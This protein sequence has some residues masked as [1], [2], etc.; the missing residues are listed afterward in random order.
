MLA[1]I[2]RYKTHPSIVKIKQLIKPNHQFGFGKFDTKEVWDEINRLD[3]SKSVSGNI[4]TTILKKLSALCIGEVTKIANSMIK[5]CLFPESLKKAD[6]SPVFKTRE[7]TAK[8]NFRPISVFP[9]ISKVFERLMSKQ[10]T[11][12]INSILPKL[13][14]EFRE[15]YSSQDALFRVI[16]Q[17]RKILDRSGKVGMV[18]MDLSKAYD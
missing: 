4:P 5:S 18:L 6:L 10:I 14:C 16:E 17:C 9:A 3:G 11:S 12:F 8:K 15:G 7:T 2:E 13:L 1:A